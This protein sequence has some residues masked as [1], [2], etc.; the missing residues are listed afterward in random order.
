MASR[1]FHVRLSG[2]GEE[3]LVDVEDAPGHRWTYGH[4]AACRAVG[5]RYPADTARPVPVGEEQ[6]LPWG[7]PLRVRGVQRW[8]VAA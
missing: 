5:G 6:T 1:Q 2:T 3:W 7:L 8:L 4:E